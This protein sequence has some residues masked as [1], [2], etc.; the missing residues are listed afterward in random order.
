MMNRPDVEKVAGWDVIRRQD[1][2]YGVYDSDGM[3][4]GPFATRAEAVEAALQS[5]RR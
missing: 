2:Q 1:G 5:P 4:M 3:R